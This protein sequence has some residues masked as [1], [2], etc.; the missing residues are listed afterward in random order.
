MKRIAFIGLVLVMTVLMLAGCSQP[1]NSGADTSWDDIKAQ[2]YFIL[3]LDDS[4]PPMGYRDDNNEIVGFD[5]DL[6]RE[7]AKR[8]GIEVKLQPLV[9][10]FI[11]EELN[12][13]KVDVIWNGCTITEKRKELFDFTKPYM[14]NE[15]VVVV[16]SGS[17]VQM[18]EDLAGLKLGIQ[19][20]SSVS[21]AL[22][23]NAAVRDS[24]G[25][26]VEFSDNTKALMDLEN[27]QLDA[28]ALDVVVFGEYNS[29][30]PG[31]FRRLDKALG[32]EQFGIGIRKADQSFKAELQKALDACMADGTTQQIAD[33][34]LGTGAGALVK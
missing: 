9:W 8:M 10:D 16:L 7:C 30:K 19:G 22:D 33:K 14:N 6:A 18:L 12:G 13:K 1:A 2:G 20:G 32:I 21:I 24:L 27:G 23:D 29:I 4:F 11:A 28:V 34:W 3:G 5:I 17:S 25:E 26:L 31:V 15:Q